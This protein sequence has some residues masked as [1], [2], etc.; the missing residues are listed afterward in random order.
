[1]NQIIIGVFDK[2]AALFGL[3]ILSFPLF[4]ITTFAYIDTRSPFFSQKRVGKNGNAFIL[5]K[6]RTMK[7]G[8]ASV[9][10]HMIDPDA[11][12]RFGKFLRKTKID[13][14]PQL[15][16][17]LKGDMSLVGPRPCLPIQNEL[18][19]ERSK[20]NVYRYKPGITGLAQINSIDMSSPRKLA[21]VDSLMLDEMTLC[22]Y[23]YLILKTLSGSG[24]RR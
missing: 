20:R 11:I 14:L 4:F 5:L 13:E 21:K 7:P 9:G 10:T 22:F 19:R 12:T 23:F 8:T 3:I 6:F 2:F 15:I 18:I 24:K 1:M 16:N 17:V